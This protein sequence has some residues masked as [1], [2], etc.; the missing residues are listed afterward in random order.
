MRYGQ[1]KEQSAELLRAALAHIGRHDATCNPLTYAVWYEYVAGI[2]AGLTRAVDE[3]LRIDPGLGDAAIARLYRDHVSE[4]DQ[5]V[6][7]RAGG[8]LGR[9]M[10]GIA[11]SAAVAGDKA[12]V[13]GEQLNELAGALDSTQASALGPMLG[14]VLDGTANMR[15]ATKELQQ[16]VIAG[17]LEIERLRGDLTRAREEAV[18]DPLTRILNRKGFDQKLQAMLQDV[19]VPGRSHCLV[20]LD[21]DRFKAVNDNYGH[22]M[23]DRVLQA[24]AEVVSSGISDPAHA[25]ARYGGEEFAVLLPQCRADDARARAELVR[26]RIKA[27]RIQDR[28]SK[29]V[30][31]TVTI[32]AGVATA[33]PEE[34]ASSL[35]ARADGAL[36]AA[37]QAGRDQV[38]FV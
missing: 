34:D 24:V 9:L 22:V 14:P 18:L 8:D 5:H 11:D 36:Y 10:S 17:R 25:V 29:Q 28:R 4:V 15:L 1:T 32:S 2:N 37:K 31:L 12:G 16:Q 13:F 23:G 38:R 27:L 26:L 35:I 33:R 6:I 20:M 19:P 30:S 21:I 3:C 7:E